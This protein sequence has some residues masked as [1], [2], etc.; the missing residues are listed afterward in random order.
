VPNHAHLAAGGVALFK[1]RQRISEILRIVPGSS[2]VVAPADTDLAIPELAQG[3]EESFGGGGYT[4]RQRAALLQLAWD[5]VS[6][7]LDGRESAFELHASGGLPGWR[8]WLRRS[9]RDYSQL[10]NAVTQ[11]IDLPMP[12]IDVGIIGTALP[13]AR[14]PVSVPPGG[15]S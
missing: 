3:L 9:F 13:S 14:R 2:L 1:A 4:A 15:K 7:A 8:H 6:S 11:L 5:H 10:A 12:E